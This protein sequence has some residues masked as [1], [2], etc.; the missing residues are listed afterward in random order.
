MD[1]YQSLFG[2]LCDLNGPPVISEM[3]D[4]I[5]TVKRQFLWKLT[6]ELF[7]PSGALKNPV[8]RSL[9]LWDD[10]KQRIRTGNDLTVFGNWKRFTHYIDILELGRP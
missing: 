3:N 1:K 8:G 5:Q 10:Q 4:I 7:D 6:T 9:I 2:M